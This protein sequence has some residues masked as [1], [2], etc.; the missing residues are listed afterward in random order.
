M[1]A[2]A[3]PTS[4]KIDATPGRVALALL[5]GSLGGAAAQAADLPLAWMIGAMMATTLAAALG[6]PVA[7]WMGLRSVMVTVLGVMLGSAFSPEIL[8]RLL[9]WALSLACLVVYAAVSGALCLQ[10]FA[11]LARFDP[12]TSYFAAM[13]GGLAEMTLV[14]GAMGGDERMISL[15]HAS[16]LLIVI[17]CLPFAF[18]L[19]V[20]YDPAL[21]P[22]SGDSLMAIDGTDLVIL[23]ACGA[24]GYF[25]ARALG[26]PA[27]PI[28]G[29]MLLSAIVHLAGL[30]AARP[31][32]ELIGLA[33]VIV[34]S[35]IGCR[36]AGIGRA[37]VKRAVAAALGGTA[38]HLGTTLAFAGALALGTGL[39]F[40]A[41]V[42]AYSPGGLAEMS[43]I[44]LALGFDRAR[45][46][47]THHIFRIF[48]IVV[49]APAAFRLL[50]RR[51][52]AE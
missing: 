51:N 12:V 36:F 2:G 28:V 22:A 49:F 19:L 1:T 29:P 35:A 8:D 31:P 4:N 50:R 10:A 6:L 48:T 40:E 39:G 15:I 47:A 37:F 52:H 30:T 7:M 33:Q 42:L 9:E 13:P 5:I 34:G 11:R 18:Q 46:V 27:A 14:G 3:A 17:L 21:R 16:R 43:L 38:I 44:A 24:L 26:V 45:F 41:L 23:A 20:G 25:G 32:S